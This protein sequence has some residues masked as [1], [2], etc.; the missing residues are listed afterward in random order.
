MMTRPTDSFGYSSVN[1]G[2]RGRS[3]KPTRVDAIGSFLQIA[4][5]SVH[6]ELTEDGRNSC[7][8]VCI[9]L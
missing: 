6:R 9:C 3:Y 2:L 4:C 7:C 8:W 5:F 1:T